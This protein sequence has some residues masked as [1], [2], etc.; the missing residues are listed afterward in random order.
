M[1]QVDAVINNCQSL[2]LK[3]RRNSFTWFS[4]HHCQGG[5]L[6]EAARDG[7]VEAAE[8]FVKVSPE[9]IHSKD[10]FGGAPRRVMVHNLWHTLSLVYIKYI[11]LSR[12]RLFAF[13]ASCSNQNQFQALRHML[14][15]KNSSMHFKKLDV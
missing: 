8:Y 5:D 12:L 4:P 10:I 15:E 14:R 2:R 1:L 3:A 7:N 9:S 13:K 6:A 11:A